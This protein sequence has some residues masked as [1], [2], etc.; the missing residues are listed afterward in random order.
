MPYTTVRSTAWGHE[1]EV[2]NILLA[3]YANVA[4]GGKANVMGIFRNIYSSA[5]P[6]RHSD[7]YLVVVLQASVSEKGQKR[8]V[9]IKLLNA[10]ATQI[11]VD[12][13]QAFTVPDAPP[14]RKTEIN[15]ILRNNCYKT[16]R[17]C[18]ALAGTRG[19]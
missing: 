6:A 2:K 13:A 4:E 15:I 7:M 19:D 16:N 3:D 5:F 17:Y 8:N 11:L 9:R 12:Y 10:D 18:Q 1:V 14:G